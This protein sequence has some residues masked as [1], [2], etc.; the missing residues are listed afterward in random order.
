MSPIEATTETTTTDDGTDAEPVVHPNLHA[1]L[2]A[3]SDVADTAP[4]TLRALRTH[5]LLPVLLRELMAPTPHGPD[6]EEG[7]ACDVDLEKKL[8]R[9]VVV[10]RQTTS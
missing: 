3:D 1:A 6:G 9:C 7:G 4:A 8:A 10:A 5:K 2:V